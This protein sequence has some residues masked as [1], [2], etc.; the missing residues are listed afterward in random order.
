MAQL[1][2]LSS[3]FIIY[4]M[5]WYNMIWYDIKEILIKKNEKYNF[6]KIKNFYT[7]QQLQT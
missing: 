7:L 2:R 4:N 1:Q 3:T 6:W 5:I